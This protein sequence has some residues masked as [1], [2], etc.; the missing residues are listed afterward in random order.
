MA[1]QPRSGVAETI[2]S[3]PDRRS[4]PKVQGVGAVIIGSEYL[5]MRG[6]VADSGG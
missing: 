3:M 5:L 1:E 4:G 2:V 6:L